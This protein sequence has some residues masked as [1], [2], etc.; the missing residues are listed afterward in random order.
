MLYPAAFS[1]Y[2]YQPTV[3]DG[4]ELHEQYRKNNWH[5][6]AEGT[7][8]RIYNFFL[9]STNRVTYN[10]GGR[11]SVDYANETPESE[12]VTPLF[13]NLMKRI[14]AVTSTTPFLFPTNSG[15]WSSTEGSTSIAWFVNFG[16]GNVNFYNSKYNTNIVV[17]PVAV[18]RFTL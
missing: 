12:A 4:E 13:A 3:G 2:L 14:Q 18:F 7:L 17:R 5:L 10:N 16:S 15:Y 1:A 6:P 9:N 11:I 8:C